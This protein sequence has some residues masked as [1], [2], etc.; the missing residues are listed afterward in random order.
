MTGRKTATAISMIHSVMRLDEASHIVRPAAGCDDE[1]SRKGKSAKPVVRMTPAIDAADAMKDSAPAPGAS[2]TS[3]A[4]ATPRMGAIHIQGHVWKLF[5][6]AP[7]CSVTV[8]AS[9]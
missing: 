6:H 2:S 9:G 5:I 1:G 8:L 7:T 4:P 3:S